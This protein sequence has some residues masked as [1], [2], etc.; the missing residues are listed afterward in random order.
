MN[1]P[2]CKF[3]VVA[4]VLLAAA[5]VCASEIGIDWGHT[6]GIEIPSGQ[7]AVQSDAVRVSDGGAFVKTGEGTLVLPLTNLNAIAEVPVEVRGGR[8]EIEP[9]APEAAAVAVPSVVADKSA[10]WVDASEEGSFVL[11]GSVVTR[12]CD[13]R[14]TDVTTPTLYNARPANAS[15]SGTDAID[16]TIVEKD[17]LKAVYFG[18]YNQQNKRYMQFYRGASSVNAIVNIRHA[19]VVFGV[20]DCYNGPLGSGA[21]PDDWFSASAVAQMSSPPKYFSIRYGEASPGAF[22]A[23]HYLDGQRFDP[24]STTVKSGFQ[25]WETHFLDYTGTAGNF[26][27]HKGAAKRQGGDYISEVILFTND[28]TVVERLQVQEYLLEKWGLASDARTTRGVAVT[29]A[30]DATAA[31]ANASA[32]EFPTSSVTRL[33]G[34]GMFEKTGVGELTID[35][36]SLDLVDYEGEFDFADGSLF[37]RRGAVPALKLTG[38]SV[39][40]FSPSSRT[41]AGTGSAEAYE[42]YGFALTKTSDGTQGQIVKKGSEEI[43]VHSITTGVERLDVMAGDFALVAT[44]AGNVVDGSSPLSATIPNADFEEPFVADTSYNRKALSTTTAFNHWFKDG[45]DVVAFIAE[46]YSP[47]DAGASSPHKRATISPY[48]IRQGYNALTIG[49][50]GSAYTTEAVFPKSGHYEMTIL[51]SSRFHISGISSGYFLSNPGYDVM[52]GDDW[53]SAQPVAHRAVSNSGCWIEVRIPLGY[54]EAGT[55]TFGFKGPQWS[56]GTTLLVDDIKVRFVGERQPLGLVAIPNGDFESVTNRTIAASGSSNQAMYPARTNANEAVGWTFV[57]S[58]T[59]VPAAAVVAAYCSPATGTDNNSASNGNELMPYGDHADG[60]AGTFHLSLCGTTGSARTTFAV[61]AGVYRLK[62]RIAQWGGKVNGSDFRNE[63]PSAVA[64]ATVGGQNVALGSV[65]TSDHRMLEYAWPNLLTVSQDGDVTLSLAAGAAADSVLVDDL[66][67][68]SVASGNGDEK[69]LVVNGSFEQPGADDGG[70]SLDGWTRVSPSF[71]STIASV[72][73]PQYD[74]SVNPG[75]NT[76]KQFGHAPYDGVAYARIFNDGGFYQA[77]TLDPGVYRL[78]FAV[79]SRVNEG[80]GNNPI[81]VWL[82][83]SSG[84]LVAEIGET[85]VNGIADIVHVWHFRVSAYGEYRLYLQGSDHW[86]QQFAVDG[87]TH[88][89]IVDGVSLKKI[90]DEL[91]PPTVSNK[92]KVVVNTGATLRLDFDG[93]MDVGRLVLG[94]SA[95]AKGRTVSAATHPEYIQGRGILTVTGK[96]AP[97]LIF[98]VR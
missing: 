9:G 64:T 29:V 56:E 10:F 28:L 4:I 90:R 58:N 69:E 50:K 62:G 49:N 88:C 73:N 72:V 48:P 23:R 98:T 45:N 96:G 1:K 66:V 41:S 37:V 36:R 32:L 47:G 59:A 93:T 18:G 77:M 24:W 31:I 51:E 61:P 11:N 95:I 25:L 75:N 38:G 91:V 13:R 57:N 20:F 82:G 17:G 94:G 2:N 89:S 40:T 60:L 35:H 76:P 34:V 52:I 42:G 44:P 86:K 30:P 14:E 81:R 22:T 21:N 8:L 87:K 53:T 70:A 6:E 79:H 80:Y 55:K 15:N 84:G 46:D 16:Q 97:G 74:Y 43:R 71:G 54:V 33:R 63:R 19:F 78:S 83:D 92:L 68:E 26:F 5:T 67:L 39:V 65:A 12:W 3:S 7:S 85:K 27:N